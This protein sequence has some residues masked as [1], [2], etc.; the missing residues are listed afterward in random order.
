MASCE[1]AQDAAFADKTS[2]GRRGARSLRFLPDGKPPMNPEEA[3]ACS[4]G[5]PGRP[6]LA[7]AI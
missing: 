2:K 3:S 5:T 4:G 1:K 7:R 6:L